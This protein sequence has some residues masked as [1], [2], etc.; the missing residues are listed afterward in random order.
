[1]QETRIRFGV[2][3][4]RKRF[5]V[6]LRLSLAAG[7]TCRVRVPAPG[8]TMAGTAGFRLWWPSRAPPATEASVAP[9]PTSAEVAGAR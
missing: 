6:W 8:T 4:E 2:S 5:G 1:M 3:E 7:Q 9:S